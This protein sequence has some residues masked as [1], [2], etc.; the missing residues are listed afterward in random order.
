[1][2]ARAIALAVALS[3][4]A[5][6]EEPPLVRP[7][8]QTPPETSSAFPYATIDEIELAVAAAGSERDLASATFRVGETLALRD[9]PFGENLVIHMRGRDRG[10]Q[11]AYGR[12][13]AVTID[14]SAAIQPRLYLSRVVRW[15]PGPLMLDPDR[16]GG[17]AGS[18]AGGR[19]AV[20]IGGG[21]AITSV[22]RFSSVTGAFETL[23][24]AAAVRLGGV[25]APLPNGR[26]LLATGVDDGGDAVATAEIIDPQ[27]LRGFQVE[28][29][30]GPALRDARAVALVD[31]SVLI[32]GG[33]QQAGGNFSLSARGFLYQVDDVGTVEPVRELGTT[34]TAARRNHTM[35]RLGDDV[36]A[37]VLI[38]GGQNDMGLAVATTEL[39]RPLAQSFEE[40]ASA[41]MITP[42]WGHAAARLPGGFV[43]IVG[44]MTRAL[45][46]DPETAV[47]SL[48]LYDPVQGRFADAGVLPAEAGASDFSITELPDGR[49]LLAGGY[50]ASGTKVATAFIIRRDPLT[51]AVDVSRTDDLS[52]PR[53]GHAATRLCDGTVLLA[54][55]TTT[56]APPE[57]YNP[58]ETGRR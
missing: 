14:G 46:A 19:D 31:G 51:G 36:G 40:V 9:V 28:S 30:P 12:T 24:D 43:L 57:R 48:E 37:D 34:M 38:T 33:D 39:Y 49:Y 18:V 44:G 53:A 5:C 2:V 32:T 8:V 15:G 55:G 22:E 25:I 13:C 10:A 54:G 17:V 29:R 52:T 58:P 42:R 26:L 41:T 50:D 47:T 11:V 1:M 21:G 45:P 35:T 16:I 23:D 3:V 56:D 20:F 27:A 4:L 6:G 7:I